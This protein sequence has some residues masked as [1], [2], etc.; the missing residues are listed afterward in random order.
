MNLPGVPLA[1]VR[2]TDVASLQITRSIN[3][4]FFVNDLCRA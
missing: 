1:S 2:L 4:Y 3:V